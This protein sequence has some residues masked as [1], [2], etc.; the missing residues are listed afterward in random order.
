MGISLVILILFLLFLNTEIF[1]TDI[2]PR[3]VEKFSEES[4]P[5]GG[6]NSFNSN[7][8]SNDYYYDRTG[9]KGSVFTNPTSLPI[10]KMPKKEISRSLSQLGV[11]HKLEVYPESFYNNCVS[12]YSHNNLKT[13][14]HTGKFTKGDF[15]NDYLNFNKNI[16][17]KQ[18]CGRSN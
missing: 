8:R 18:S 13:L 4:Y 5:V 11:V 16:L 1:N 3:C 15:I 9:L 12:D 7:S 14:T 10:Y 6:G 2:A 17:V